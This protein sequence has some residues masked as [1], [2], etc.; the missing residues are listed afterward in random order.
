MNCLGYMKYVSI[1]S[2]Q[3]FQLCYYSI[4]GVV[5]FVKKNCLWRW[6]GLKG[7]ECRWGGLYG[8]CM[9]NWKF[10]KLSLCIR[11]PQ[12]RPEWKNMPVYVC[13]WPL[14]AY[15]TWTMYSGGVW[16]PVTYL[17]AF[18]TP[19]DFKLSLA[20]RDAPG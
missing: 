9:V 10:P 8:N 17:W 11:F 18:S 16:A 15:D 1:N 6:R 7:F 5:S 3:V 4:N 2:T 14:V 19:S 20:F 12:Y 13:V